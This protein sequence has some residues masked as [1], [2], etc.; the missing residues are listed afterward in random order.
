MQLDKTL[1]LISR[2]LVR[3][4]L[5]D[6]SVDWKSNLAVGL[7]Q[8]LLL[9]ESGG[10]AF[11]IAWGNQVFSEG[12]S[13]HSTSAPGKFGG[14][15]RKFSGGYLFGNLRPGLNY[16]F[17][18]A[19]WYL[20]PTTG[21]SAANPLVT[22]ADAGGA[23]ATVYQA[24]YGN[25]DNGNGATFTQTGSSTGISTGTSL[26]NTW[27]HAACWAASSAS[28]AVYFNGGNKTT[29]NSGAGYAAGIKKLVIGNDGQGDNH[30]GRIELACVW[31]R[32]LRD[33]EIMQ[34]YQDPLCFLRLGNP[35]ISWST[36]VILSGSASG[37][38]T[39]SGSATTI[40]S[41]VKSV[42]ESIT[43]SAT[44]KASSIKSVTESVAASQSAKV[45]TNLKSVS[46]SIVVSA[47]EVASSVRAA[48]GVIGA[49]AG[50]QVLSQPRVVTQHVTASAVV[51]A[52]G[53]QVNAAG[54]VSASASQ[55]VH[56]P[57]MVSGRIG[58]VALVVGPH[59]PPPS[60]VPAG[61]MLVFKGGK[62]KKKEHEAESTEADLTELTKISL[63][64]REMEMFML[65]AVIAEEDLR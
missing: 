50:V 7:K 29:G 23:A 27:Q 37:S 20:S 39:V 41:S 56:N 54:R 30:Q 65:A 25:F 51:I 58:A 28:Q 46:E 34:L 4:K 55:V 60:V 63:R 33:A 49:S 38:G 5:G 47:S 40:A 24:L 53:D 22:L 26:A 36:A 6:I 31:N 2:R 19:A 44:E 17:T 35:V 1:R 59:P 18:L 15:A 61:S 3:Q 14:M 52:S 42:S 45:I 62:R 57:L 64:R 10:Q 43:A 11:D 8:C 12:I 21:V 13:T 32:V 16:P 9:G 48:S